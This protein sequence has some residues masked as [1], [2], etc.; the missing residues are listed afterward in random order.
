MI[1]LLYKFLQV[2]NWF[3]NRRYARKARSSKGSEMTSYSVMPHDDSV[4]TGNAAPS[5]S[6]PSASAPSGGLSS[7]ILS[8]DDF[9]LVCF[10]VQLPLIFHLIFITSSFF[11]CAL[12]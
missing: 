9:L 6:A 12:C 1:C 4:S 2:W 5:A 8:L 10:H 11:V 7:Y 3:Q